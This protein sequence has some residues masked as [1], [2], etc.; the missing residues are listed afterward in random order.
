MG[1]LPALHVSV[2]KEEGSRGTAVVGNGPILIE[3]HKK[4]RNN[5]F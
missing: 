5:E 2:R 4:I 3:D 1:D